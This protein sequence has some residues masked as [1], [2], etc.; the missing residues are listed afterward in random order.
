MLHLMDGEF[1]T[2]AMQN[3]MIILCV[4]VCTGF[5]SKGFC[6]YVHT[7]NPALEK[8]KNISERDK[9]YIKTVL[10]LPPRNRVSILRN[11]GSVSFVVLRSFVFSNNLPMQLR[12]H[13]LISLAYA[14]PNAATAVVESALQSSTWFLRNA[15]L[16]A[17][18]SINL[19]RAL[20]WAGELLN[21]PALVVRT[22]AVKMIREQK[23][24]QYKY[25][26]VHKLNAEDS[27]YKNKS[28]WIRHHIVYALADFSES[29]EEQFFISL[30]DDEDERLYPPAIIALEKLTNESFKFTKVGKKRSSD[31]QKRRWL[32]WWSE[33]QKQKSLSVN[34]E[35][36]ASNFKDPS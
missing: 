6:Q 30:L 8:N 4:L 24:S 16:I 35:D 14:Y 15:G 29:G 12:W 1:Y 23:A 21:D 3:S 18:E 5:V 7:M 17:M 28:L 33:K 9:E 13:A 34:S 11:H 2:P 32:S 25:L 31:R 20:Y 36:V 22:A 19:K 10:T 26:L 27:F